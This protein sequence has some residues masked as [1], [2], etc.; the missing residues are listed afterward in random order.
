M[1]GESGRALMV[2]LVPYSFVIRLSS[3]LLLF[4][5]QSLRPHLENMNVLQDILI[6]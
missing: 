2:M 4:A 3:F 1:D 6:R 5:L